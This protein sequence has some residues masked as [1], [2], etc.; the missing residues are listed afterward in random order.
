MRA[1]TPEQI[2]GPVELTV[3]DLSF[4]SLRLVLP[5]LAAA[6]VADGD[7]V[8]MVK[9]QF[10][11]GR[12]RVGPAA[13]CAN[14]SCGRR[15]CS[16]WRPRR[17]SSGWAWP[18][19]W[20]AR[21][22]GRPATWSSSSGCAAA[23]RPVDPRPACSPRRRQR[24]MTERGRDRGDDAYRAAGHPY[25]PEGQH[26]ARPYG[27]RRSHRG[28]LHG[29]GDG[30]RGGRPGPARRRPGSRAPTRPRAPRSSSRS[31]GTARSCGRPNW[32]GRPPRRCSVSTWVGSGSWPRRRSPTSTSPCATSWPG[33]TRSR[34]GSPSTSTVAHDGALVARSW[35]LNE[36]SVEKGARE[37]MLE[38]R[39]DV[40]GRPLSRYGCDGVICATPTGSTA[41]AFS[42]G[43]P[44][45][46]PGVEALLLVPISAHALFSRALVTAPSSTI[47]VTVDPHAPDAV[48]F[49][50]GRRMFDAA[51]GAVV[52]VCR[53]APAG[54]GG[55]AASAAVHRPAGGQVR[56]CRS[57]AGGPTIRG[58]TDGDFCPVRR[59]VDADG[60]ARMPHCSRCVSLT[61]CVAPASVEPGV[62]VVAGT[63]AIST[64]GPSDW[65]AGSARATSR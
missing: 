50:D 40:D 34:S 7:L 55:P 30:R 3:A 5:A 6:T 15:R 9:P 25:R 26:R 53:G 62:R 60:P 20:R 16:T 45:V 58:D 42:A 43:G 38:V 47:T 17:P 11:V 54:P 37:R 46:W 57:K 59:H 41:Y 33:R 39:V 36:V 23:L 13:W 24:G 56:A 63:V 2:G 10:E 28:R 52:T 21:C 8:P 65:S 32:P 12:D 44:V 61:T 22:P 14:R 48:V 51:P 1:L 49:C 29:A 4:I 19:S 31:V 18:A 64:A 27:R 35:A